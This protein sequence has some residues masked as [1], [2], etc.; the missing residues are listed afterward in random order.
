M[1][2]NPTAS[3]ILVP[4]NRLLDT[5]NAVIMD[6][7][8]ET[9]AGRMQ[10]ALTH[11]EVVMQLMASITDLLGCIHA[12]SFVQEC[13]RDHC[14][15]LCSEYPA[16]VQKSHHVQLSILTTLDRIT[17]FIQTMCKERED[18]TTEIFADVALFMAQDKKNRT[19]LASQAIKVCKEIMTELGKFQQRTQGMCTKRK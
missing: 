6:A 13:S 19:Q 11:I 7:M 18:H 9:T 8:Y 12:L 14:S 16:L 1:T 3:E 4:V 15:S 5:M 10:V 2:M 17:V